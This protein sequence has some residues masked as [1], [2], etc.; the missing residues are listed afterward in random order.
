MAQSFQ[1][2]RFASACPSVPDHPA[3]PVA[4]ARKHDDVGR[5]HGPAQQRG[6]PLET[7]AL[8]GAAGG[9]ARAQAAFDEGDER[10]VGQRR[11]DR[12]DDG[13]DEPGKRQIHH[14]VAPSFRDQS[15]YCKTPATIATIAS[16]SGK[17][18]FQPNRMS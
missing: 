9:G 8:V 14:A 16:E 12:A 1:A 6:L 3:K 17:N 15:P 5:E 10:N 4:D 13:S 18:T 7:L 11:N 2:P